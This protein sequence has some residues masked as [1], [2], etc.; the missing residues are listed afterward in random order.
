MKKKM[1]IGL[2]VI[3]TL[4]VLAAC[5]NSA[6]GSYVG[7]PDVP[8]ATDET[9]E[10]VIDGDK[11][12]LVVEASILGT[13]STDTQE[14]KVDQKEKVITMGDGTR[15]TYEL[16]DGSLKIVSDSS[17]QLT[18]EVFERKSKE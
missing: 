8:F 16:V 7:H 12:T 13:S 4:I 14:V 18:G 2:V 10:I 11:G 1:S 3:L 15:L 17:N 6:N 9:V 5:G